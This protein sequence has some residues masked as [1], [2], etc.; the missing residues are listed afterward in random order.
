MTSKPILLNLKEFEILNWVLITGLW[1]ET[2]GEKTFS[3]IL[4]NKYQLYELCKKIN[5]KMYRA[6]IRSIFSELLRQGRL[7]AI[8]KPVLEKPKTINHVGEDSSAWICQYWENVESNEH[9]WT[10][11]EGRIEIYKSVLLT[12]FLICQFFSR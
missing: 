11:F 1:F 5:K 7:V 3:K 8:E 2:T 10:N 4:I 6:A 9:Q 12:Y